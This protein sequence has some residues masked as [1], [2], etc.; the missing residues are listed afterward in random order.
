MDHPNDGDFGAE[1]KKKTPGN[2]IG[3]ALGVWET[4]YKCQAVLIMKQVVSLSLE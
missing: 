4:A 2:L 1:S 3:R